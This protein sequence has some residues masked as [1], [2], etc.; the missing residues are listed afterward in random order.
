MSGRF[1]YLSFRDCD[2]D[3][4][5][6]DSLKNDYP[7]FERWFSHK[8]SNNDFAYVYREYGTIFAFQYLKNECEEIELQNSSIPNENRVKI[9]TLKI[10]EDAKGRR[11]G[12]GLLG[13]ALWTW[14]QA[15]VNQIYLT[16]F[17][18]H[19][20]LINVLKKFGFEDVGINLRGE[21]V[22]FKDKNRLSHDDPYKMF[23][24]ISNGFEHAKYLPIQEDY[25]DTL[26]PYSELSRTSQ[27]VLNLSVAN[28]MTK[29]FIGFPRDPESLDY[30]RNQ[31]IAIY[32]ITKAQTRKTFLSV[33][34]SFGV[35]VD[36]RV[37][38]NKRKNIM[39]EEE[40]LSFVGNKSYFNRE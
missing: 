2:L 22:F 24:Y 26:F 39:T 38:I 14:Q 12:E 18:H 4:P 19:E 37:V 34:S 25:H 10:E 7:E 32:R 35:V 20:M 16:V 1:E 11:L 21:H 9:G 28:G 5:F 31:P 30:K 27:N 17:E 36:Y 29:V 23:P 15:Q 3:D 8:Q 40:Y 33:V 6:F 13:I